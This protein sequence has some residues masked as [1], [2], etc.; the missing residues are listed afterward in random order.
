M[1]EKKSSGIVKARDMLIA[2]YV[3][4]GGDYAKIVH[5]IQSKANMDMDFV[6]GVKDSD[7]KAITILDPD[8]PER[9]KTALKPPIVIEY[10]GNR[11]RIVRAINSGK[12]TFVYGKNRF[13]LKRDT[14]V[15]VK[16]DGTVSVGGFGTLTTS[17]NGLSG[18]ELA[19]KISGRILIEKNISMDDSKSIAEAS[20]I[21]SIALMHTPNTDV[22]VVPTGRKSLNNRLIIEGA[23]LAQCKED[24]E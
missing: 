19:V 6:M 21:A 1:G 22:Y 5:D 18:C 8:Y 7:V 9:L 17:P 20:H 12:L 2:L 24:L 10:S 13:G 15:R 4:N 11:T 16:D 23:L 3:K 14:I